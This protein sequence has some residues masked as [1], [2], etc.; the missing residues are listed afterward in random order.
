LAAC[1]DDPRTGQRH[2][3]RRRR[4]VV[5][6]FQLAPK[7]APEW[8]ADAGQLWRFAEEADTR[9]NST[10]ARELEV[11]LPHELN[12]LQR[13]E[14]AKDIGGELVN[15]YQVAA[16]VAIHEPD[17]GPNFHAHIL[18]T[19]RR[20]GADGFTE[21]T[22]ELDDQKQ[23]RA[24]VLH[25]RQSVE[26]LTNEALRRAGLQNRIDARSLAAQG[27][28]RL[29]TI[30][31]FHD[32]GRRSANQEIR[33]TNALIAVPKF[34]RSRMQRKH[35]KRRL[36]LLEFRTLRQS[37]ARQKA[38]ALADLSRELERVASEDKTAAKVYRKR[39]KSWEKKHPFKYIFGR[40]L[41][42]P[43]AELARL[44]KCERA[45]TTKARES[46]AAIE[47]RGELAQDFEQQARQLQNRID[48]VRSPQAVEPARAS[49][50]EPKPEG[51]QEAPQ[52]PPRRPRGPGMR[53]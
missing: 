15:R 4:G 39:A 46:L 17:A 16:S 11:S 1:F 21:K 19:T 3:Y 47:A 5:S 26:T 2:D 9:K 38:E 44:R 13:Q 12:A 18:F 48:R 22:R 52:G 29:P 31:E 53:R 27:L 8:A 40:L 33:L 49:M 37:E 51:P 10:L 24:E 14:L 36:Q 34:D 41:G 6:T 7:N 42:R 45:L 28:T 25:I 32:P 35:E 43:P 20:L 23:G 50:A 30:H